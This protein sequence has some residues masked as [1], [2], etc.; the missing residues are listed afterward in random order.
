MQPP[1]EKLARNPK[2]LQDKLDAIQAHFPF[3][4]NPEEN[5]ERKKL[6]KHMDY[7]GNGYLNLTEIENG[8]KYM[9]D[10]PEIMQRDSVINRAFN[11]ARTKVK[12]G[13]DKKARTRNDE[14]VTWSEYRYLLQYICEYYQYQIV[15]EHIDTGDDNKIAYEEFI[16]AKR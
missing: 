6:W 8:W 5:K 16:Q 11:I 2:E 3:R 13:K 9:G 1:Q 14:F 12:S 4:K 10:I 15:F 7:N